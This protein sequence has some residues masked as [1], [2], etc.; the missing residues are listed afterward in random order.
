[1]FPYDVKSMD[2]QRHQQYTGAGNDLIPNI[3]SRLLYTGK[4]FPVTGEVSAIS[5]PGEGRCQAMARETAAFDALSPDRRDELCE[6][7]QA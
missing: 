3:L 5:R 6:A 7:I 2:S 1:M 4:R